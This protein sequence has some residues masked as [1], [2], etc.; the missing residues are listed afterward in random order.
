MAALLNIVVV[1][2]HD[3]L[4]QVM[5]DVLR[6]F[7]HRVTGLS[8]AEEIDDTAV[9][10]QPDLYIIDLNLPGEDG[11]SLTQRIRRVNGTVGIIM[12]TARTQLQE[13]LSGYASGADIYLS[14]PVAPD[15]LI[16]AISALTRRLI[17]EGNIRGN[18]LSLD[19][20]RLLLTGP[21]GDVPVTDSEAA[22]LSALSQSPGQRMEIW[23]IVEMI[24][25]NMELFSKSNLEVRIVRLRKKITQVG[26]DEGAIKAIRLQGYQLCV[27]LHLI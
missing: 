11:I 6:Q 26:G 17:P 20:R 23:Q 9:G 15:E 27:P 8:C 1:E 24:G 21:G 5:V 10:P 12:V 18:D 19:M 7:G 4:R 14:K 22:I 16:A 2:D 13:K 3:S 25:I